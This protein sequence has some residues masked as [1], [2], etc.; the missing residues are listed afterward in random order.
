PARRGAARDHP[1]AAR[2]HAGPDASAPALSAL[3]PGPE[4]RARARGRLRHGRGAARRRG[5]RRPARGGRRRR[6]EPDDPEGRADAVP[7]RRGGPHHAPPGR[8]RPASVPGRRLRR[9]PGRHRHPA[10]LRS[11]AR[12]AGDG[13]RREAGRQRRAPGPGLRHR[14]RHAPGP[15]AH[16]A[17]PA[18]GGGAHLRRAPQ[19]AAPARPAPARGAQA[20]EAPHRR[21]PGHDARALDAD[22]PRAPGRERRAVRPRG[23]A[24]GPALARRLHGA[25]GA[26]GVRADD[27]LLRRRRGQGVRV[28]AA[29][30]ALLVAATVAPAAEPSKAAAPFDGAAAL[31]QVERLVA[32][33]PRPAGSLAAAKARAYILAELRAAGIAARI[34]PFEADTPHGRLKMANVVAAL[35]GRRADMIGDRELGI[36]REALSTEWLTDIIWAA[37]ARRGEG[38]HFLPDALSVEDDHVPFLRAGV[39]SALLIDFDFPPWH[40][41]EDTLDKVSARSLGI[42]GNVLLDALPAIEERLQRSPGGTRP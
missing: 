25:R 7:R 38:V 26:R 30:V 42:V 18:R 19:R 3:R 9:R 28:G 12:G 13:A 34:E 24:G 8:R 37:A 1:R 15:R 39:P 14:R 11:A 22:L 36:R 20:R 40:T 4:G 33:G 41:P 6:P 23:R 2:A 17:H 32:L 21:L 29:G 5:A 35:D 10:R 27:E 16:R 31:R